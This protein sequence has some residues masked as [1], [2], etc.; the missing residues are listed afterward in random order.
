MKVVNLSCLMLSRDGHKYSNSNAVHVEC[1]EP[2]V[3]VLSPEAPVLSP[4]LLSQRRGGLL[5]VKPL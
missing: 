4:I 2:P 3:L 1:T 5:M